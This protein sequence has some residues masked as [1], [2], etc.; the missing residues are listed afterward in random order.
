M[1]TSSLIN[2]YATSTSFKNYCFVNDGSTAYLYVDGVAQTL[3]G[4]T[5]S[6]ISI[7]QNIRV[8]EFVGYLQD[9]RI[10]N[11]AL[12]QDEINDII[13]YTGQGTLTVQNFAKPYTNAQIDDK[14][15]NIVIPAG[16]S[17]TDTQAYLTANNYATL[18]DIPAAYTDT[19]TQAYLTANNYL[20]ELPF[21]SS[22]SS[23]FNVSLGYLELSFTPFTSANQFIQSVNSSFTVTG[24]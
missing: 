11:K 14:I 5:T 7:N 21:I 9:L 24:N 18:S 12:S 20:Q 2:G 15:D 8:G 23:D 1:N 16:Y 19:Q 4:T 13:G 22:A 17:D 6:L 3:T 10:Y